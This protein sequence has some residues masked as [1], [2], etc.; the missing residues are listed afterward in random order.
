[1]DH[2]RTLITLILKIARRGDS[3]GRGGRG[4][5]GA[6]AR[7]GRGMLSLTRTC[8]SRNDKERTHNRTRIHDKEVFAFVKHKN[9]PP[10]T[11]Q[12]WICSPHKVRTLTIMHCTGSDRGGRGG[13]R[14]AAGA[15]RGAPR[16]GR[17]RGQ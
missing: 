10:T 9:K 14:G 3:S 7:G 2:R 4:R 8:S 13:A 6:T 11:V 12:L 5:G 16:G 1:V 17:G 15:G